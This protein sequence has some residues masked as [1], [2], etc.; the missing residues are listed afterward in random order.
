MLDVPETATDKE[1]K[2]AYRKKAM[3]LH[4]DVNKAPDARE[5][6][7]ECKTAYET[8]ADSSQRAAYDNSRRAWP[9]AGGFAT[10]PGE[11]FGED[12]QE[13][14]KYARCVSHSLVPDA[15]CIAAFCTAL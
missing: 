7:I 8:L 10:G 3:K 13:F 4:P 9:G 15:F 2:A 6:F 1:I 12:W 11:T 14:R 5:R